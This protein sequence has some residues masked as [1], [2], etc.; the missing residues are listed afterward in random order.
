MAK[1]GF[2]VENVVE[3]SQT[4]IAHYADAPLPALLQGPIF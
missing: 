1:F 2:T 3:K 4:L